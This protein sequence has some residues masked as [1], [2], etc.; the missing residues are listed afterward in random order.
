MSKITLATVKKFIKQDGLYMNLKRKFDGMIDGE[1]S[2][3]EGFKPL[4]RTD[5]HIDSTLGVKGAWFV[6]DSRD[7]FREYKDEQYE[8]INVYNSCGSFI[9]AK[10][11]A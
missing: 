4:E 1:R 8:G 6:G 10:K 11:I 7:R 3:N 5:W 9:I 2:Y